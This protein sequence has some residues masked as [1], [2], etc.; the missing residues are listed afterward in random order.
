MCRRRRRTRSPRPALD[1]PAASDYSHMTMVTNSRTVPAGVFKARC[2]ALLDE[3]ARLGGILV[4][5]KRGKPVA[6][7]LPF[8][9]GKPAKLTGSVLWEKDIV[10]PVGA[11][12]EAQ[13]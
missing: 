9:G 2:L 1:L 5:T 7:V 6:R 12:W 13:S 4:V 11:S 10:S 8:R 3:V